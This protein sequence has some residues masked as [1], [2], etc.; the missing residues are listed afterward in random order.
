MVP[1]SHGEWLAARVPTGQ[2]RLT[3]GDGHLTL[4]TDLGPVHEWLRHQ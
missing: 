2:T 3:D 1:F 4:I